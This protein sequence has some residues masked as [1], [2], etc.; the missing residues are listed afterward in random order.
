MRYTVPDSRGTTSKVDLLVAGLVNKS[1]NQQTGA[2]VTRI[3]TP[4]NEQPYPVQLRVCNE[5]APAGCTLS[6][7]QNVQSYGRLDGMLSDIGAPAV[8]GKSVTWTVTGSSNG[9]SAQL[10]VRVNGGVDAAHRPRPVGSVQPALHR[11]HGRLRRGRQA[12]GDAPGRPP[13]GP[14]LGDQAPTTRRPAAYRPPG[15]AGR[16]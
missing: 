3:S 1:F 6:A 14:W 13:G 10:A 5:K 2:N 4:S 15:V 16:G 9:D 7:V 12:R 11:H 8:N